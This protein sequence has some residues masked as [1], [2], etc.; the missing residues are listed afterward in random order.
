MAMPWRPRRQQ[1]TDKKEGQKKES[2][3]LPPFALGTLNRGEA[4]L[5]C[6]C[7]QPLFQASPAGVEADR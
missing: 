3:L 7:L 4:T 2:D 5:D 1:Q 6:G